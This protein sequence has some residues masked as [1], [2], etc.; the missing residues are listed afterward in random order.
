MLFFDDDNDIDPNLTKMS[1]DIQ[2]EDHSL[3]GRIRR[4]LELC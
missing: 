2:I 1:N 3:R 4:K